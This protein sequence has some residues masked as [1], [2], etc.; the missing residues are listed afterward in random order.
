MSFQKKPI[1]KAGPNLQDIQRAVNELC[2]RDQERNLLE[3][4]TIQYNQLPGGVIAEVKPGKGGGSDLPV[5]RP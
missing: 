1:R 2:Q 4:Q 5:W 3:S